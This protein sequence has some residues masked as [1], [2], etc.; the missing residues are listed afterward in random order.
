M[1]CLIAETHETL[2]IMLL[3]PNK[4]FMSHIRRYRLRIPQSRHNW[5]SPKRPIVTLTSTLSFSMF[6]CFKQTLLSWDLVFKLLRFKMTGD[7]SNQCLES[8]VK[9]GI[10]NPWLDVVQKEALDLSV[11]KDEDK[12]STIT[13]TNDLC[14]YFNQHSFSPIQEKI[15][16]K[17]RKNPYESA[18]SS[19]SRKSLKRIEKKNRAKAMKKIENIKESCDCRFC[20]EDHILSMRLRSG[21]CNYWLFQVLLCFEVLWI[22]FFSFS[23]IVFF[24]VFRIWS[25]WS[26][27]YCSYTVPSAKHNE[28]ATFT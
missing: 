4:T 25:N 3:S 13:F 21:S 24:W 11:K 16:F 1:L 12:G 19:N 10:W 26:L 27:L 17:N 15:T 7:E 5:D 9:S 20:Y 2:L 6:R 22:N 8:T 28:L 23:V 14:T 18:K